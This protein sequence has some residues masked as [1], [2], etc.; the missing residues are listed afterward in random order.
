MRNRAFSFLLT[1]AIGAGLCLEWARGGVYQEVGGQVV[2]EAEHF[3]FR[4]FEFTDAE[5]PHHFHLVPDE[6]GVTT[7][8]HPWGDTH[9]PDFMSARGG[10]FLQILP[11]SGQNKGNCTS[12]PN[13]NVGFPP[14]AEYKVEITTLG[15]FQLYLRQVGFDG[16]SDSFF[17]QILEFAPPGHGPNFYRFSPEPDAADFATLRNNPNDGST[18]D[19]G[20]SGYAA[21]AP[22]VDGDGGEVPTLYNITKPGLYTIRLS[23][24]EDGSAIDGI[25]RQL[26]SLPAPTNPGPPESDVSTSAPPYI[27]AVNPTPGQQQVPPDNGFAFQLVDAARPVDGTSIQLIIDGTKVAPV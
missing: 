24:G 21:P 17:A 18:A 2:V 13:E 7:P 8:E 20:W 5:V 15:T 25:I 11:D 10:K 4:N 12:C 23:Q 16:G 22:R 14:Y 19:Q 27:R 1:S 3:D 9:T 26:V 6:D